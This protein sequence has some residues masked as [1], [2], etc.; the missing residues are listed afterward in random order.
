MNRLH[1]RSRPRTA[2]WASPNW[3]LASAEPGACV[4]V[5]SSASVRYSSGAD[6]PGI[7]RGRRCCRGF[8]FRQARAG[9]LGAEH[10]RSGR[11]GTVGRAVLVTAAL[12]EKQQSSA[13]TRKRQRRASAIEGNGRFP[14]CAQPTYPAFPGASR[15]SAARTSAW[16]CSSKTGS[17]SI[18]RT[19]P[20][21][22]NT[23]TSIPSSL[24]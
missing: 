24:A 21:S 13:F 11:G 1:R 14:I 2:E 22:H 23:R 12:R 17:F 18:H 20:C 7:R 6:S 9:G 5:R 15:P 16:P 4:L 3:T 19:N 10:C 8:R